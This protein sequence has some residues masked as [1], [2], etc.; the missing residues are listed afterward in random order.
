MTNN[1]NV[2]CIHAQAAGANGMSVA[3]DTNVYTCIHPCTHTH[4]HTLEFVEVFLFGCG[5]S[6]VGMISELK[7]TVKP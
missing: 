5:D 1:V 7:L 3:H 6:T 4:T 2:I